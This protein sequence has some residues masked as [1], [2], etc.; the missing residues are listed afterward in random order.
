MTALA[1]LVYP[2]CSSYSE[3]QTIQVQWNPWCPGLVEDRNWLTSNLESQPVVDIEVGF[4]RGRSPNSY[5]FYPCYHYSERASHRPNT[6]GQLDVHH[7]RLPPR[8]PPAR[9]R[10]LPRTPLGVHHRMEHNQKH[11]SHGEA[12]LAITPMLHITCREETM[13]LRLDWRLSSTLLKLSISHCRGSPKQGIENIKSLDR[14]M[15]RALDLAVGERVCSK[16][17]A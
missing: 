7:Q 12:Y 15:S 4:L 11:Q 10:T 8:F 3:T 17:C 16:E 6:E 5:I 2:R 9:S 1:N 14:K 13:A